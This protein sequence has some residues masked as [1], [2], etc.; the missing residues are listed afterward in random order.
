M[1]TMARSIT[2]YFPQARAVEFDP[3]GAHYGCV[4]GFD[5]IKSLHKDSKCKDTSSKSITKLHR[6]LK[7]FKTEQV[8]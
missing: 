3:I 2:V 5:G 7:G 6:V 1:Q 8:M 4:T